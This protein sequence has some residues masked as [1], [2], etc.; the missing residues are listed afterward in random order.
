MTNTL[1][2][3]ENAITNGSVGAY[4]PADQAGVQPIDHGDDPQTDTTNG[5]S[6]PDDEYLGTVVNHHFKTLA[7]L[8]KLV[9]E[10]PTRGELVSEFGYVEDGPQ[11]YKR[12]TWEYVKKHRVLLE[13]LMGERASLMSFMMGKSP[14]YPL[15]TSLGKLLGALK[16]AEDGEQPQ[17]SDKEFIKGLVIWRCIL[18]YLL[19]S[20]AP[21]N[22]KVLTSG[23]WEHVV[24][25]I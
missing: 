3:V 7:T 22:S 19:F 11:V 1:L 10:F 14:L 6:D 15:L 24:P 9:S 12:L 13:A 21:D 18:I 20:T 2:R 8:G 5:Q 17:R 23:S 25:V 16:N 4:V